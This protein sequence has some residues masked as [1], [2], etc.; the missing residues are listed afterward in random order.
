MTMQLDRAEYS[1]KDPAFIR[2]VKTQPEARECLFCTQPATDWCHV[3]HGSSRASDFLG[4]PACHEHHMTIYHTQRGAVPIIKTATVQR[5]LA[6]WFTF[7]LGNLI[8][9]YAALRMAAFKKGET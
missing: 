1:R 3:E 6:Y 9:R 7:D 2:W 8:R 5:A 4:H